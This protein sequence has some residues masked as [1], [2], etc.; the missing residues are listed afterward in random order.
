LFV[1]CPFRKL[2]SAVEYQ[3]RHQSSHSDALLQTRPESICSNPG[4][5]WL[6]TAFNSSKL[7]NR[8]PAEGKVF[9]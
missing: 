7:H 8:Q 5:L 9:S 2:I 3:A 4:L 1:F 6:Q